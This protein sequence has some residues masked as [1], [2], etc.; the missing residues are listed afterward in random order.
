MHVVEIA[1]HDCAAYH[2][3]ASMACNSL[4]TLEDA[5]ETLLKTVGADRSILVPLVR[6]ALDNWASLEAASSPVQSPR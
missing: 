4:V 1:D 2:A 6:A 5:A 3:A